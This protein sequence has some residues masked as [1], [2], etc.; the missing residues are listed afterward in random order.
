F[1]IE[2]KEKSRLFKTTTQISHELKESSTIIKGYSQILF[3]DFKDK[4]DWGSS[5]ESN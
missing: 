2:F 4:L 5:F 3:E 1:F